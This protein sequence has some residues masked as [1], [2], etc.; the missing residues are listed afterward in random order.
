MSDNKEMSVEAQEALINAKRSSLVK[1]INAASWTP[2]MELLMKQWGEKSA[3]LRFIHSK[4][5]TKWKNFSNNLTLTTII[6]STV[7]SAVSLTAT[8]VED[9]Y[10]KNAILY[11]VG[12]V[13]LISSFVQSV[14]KFYN[15]EEKAADHTA[16]AK[17]FGSFYRYMTLQMG[18]SR[19]DRLPSDQLS[20]WALKEYER[21]QQDAPP[22]SGEAIAL[23]NETFKESSQAV[24]DICEDKFEIKVY[25]STIDEQE[26][27]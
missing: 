2:H 9:E 12:A 16:V 5:A 27:F 17:Q 13:G 15:A 1:K 14:K 11:G 4:S 20:E 18:M 26:S 8:S 22:V 25:S 6:I 3:G 7:S 10:T 19:E 23:F 21:L 24:P